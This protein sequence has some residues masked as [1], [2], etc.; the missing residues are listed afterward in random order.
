M[1]NVRVKSFSSWI[2]EVRKVWLLDEEKSRIDGKAEPDERV[3]VPEFIKVFLRFVKEY[4]E[5]CT[6]PGFDVSI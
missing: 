6:V 4:A 5:T 2:C 1:S 3:D